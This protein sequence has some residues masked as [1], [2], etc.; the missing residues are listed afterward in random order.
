[1][2]SLA[3]HGGG[4]ILLPRLDVGKHGHKVIESARTQNG[5]WQVVPAAAAFALVVETGK[6]QGIAVAGE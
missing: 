1:L 3:N 4:V 2:K 6:E 5:N